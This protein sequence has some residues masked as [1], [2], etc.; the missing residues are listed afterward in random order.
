M[1]IFICNI[2]KE[3]LFCFFDVFLEIRVKRKM[4][5]YLYISY[6][7]LLYREIL[8]I[9]CLYDWNFEIVF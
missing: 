7:D 6:V 5:I 1:N 9:K 8:N 4:N 3:M 2:N